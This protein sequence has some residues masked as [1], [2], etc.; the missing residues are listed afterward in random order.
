MAWKLGRTFQAMLA[1]AGIA[2]SV[3]AADI[4]DHPPTFATGVKIGEITSESVTIWSRLCGPEGTE[5]APGLVTI[6]CWPAGNPE[7][8]VEVKNVP[9]DPERDFTC[10][11]V[12]SGLLPGTTYEGK[13]AAHGPDGALGETVAL[14][15]KTAPVASQPAEVCAVIVTCQG[16]E[17][18]DDPQKGHWV[19][20]HMPSHNP[21]FFIH[22]GDV[23]YY[24]K[25]KAMPVSTNVPAARQR[26]NKMFAYPWNRDFHRSGG[27]FFMK[28]DHDTLKNDCWPGQSYGEL[29]WEDGLKLFREQTPQGP[30]PYRRIRWGKDLECWLLEGR[31]YRSPNNSPD[32]PD[33]TLLGK[34]QK[35][36]LKETLQRSDAS[37]KL[38]VFPVP[39]VGPG[40]A[41]K[42]DNLANKA[43]AHEGDELREF[44][45][46]IPNTYVVC[47]DRHW[48]Y[49]SKDPTTGLVEICCGPI[50]NAHAQVGSNA[51]ENQAMHLYYGGGKGGYLR[52]VV[53]RVDGIP[54]I[55]F[56][57]H[58]D[59]TSGGAINHELWYSKTDL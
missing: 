37:F 43:F 22:T 42:G 8:L 46:S 21:D 50:N 48:Q 35:A 41:G 36:W 3:M 14:H 6:R 26:W 45:S 13:I 55:G 19:Y 34:A 10:Q 47:G 38:V 4:P 54:R 32:G 9:V 39:V 31:D 20:S 33:K 30:L 52:V 15:F 28:D 59:R 23:V 17:T 40:K 18:V 5:G 11:V 56:L 25:G 7:R 57:W 1:L 44:L 27:S 29:T 12:L 58:G 16:H 2:G 51:K 53:H 24:D 49:A